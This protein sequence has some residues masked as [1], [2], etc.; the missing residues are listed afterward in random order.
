VVRKREYFT[1]GRPL[2]PTNVLFSVERS[3]PHSI[4]GSLCPLESA[5]PSNDISIGSSVFAQ[6]VC[7]LDTETHTLTTLR[8]TS[9]AGYIYAQRAGD[10]A[11]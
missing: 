10:A 8:R 11:E 1:L 5:P 9:V 4:H 2:L 7:V 3:R 6:L